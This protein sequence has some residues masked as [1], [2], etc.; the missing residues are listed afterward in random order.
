MTNAADPIT[1]DET[2]EMQRVLEPFYG[3]QVRTWTITPKHSSRS[4]R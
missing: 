2:K 4:V 1:A 3:S